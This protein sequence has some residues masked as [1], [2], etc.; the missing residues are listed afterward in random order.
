MALGYLFGQARETLRHLAPEDQFAL[1][2]LCDRIQAAEA[3][4]RVSAAGAF[5]K[6]HTVCRGI[7][8]R[9][10]D[11]N[12]VLDYPDFVYILN[13]MPEMAEKVAVCLENEPAFFAA[14][15]IFLENGT[16]PCIFPGTIMPEVCITTFC[17]YESPAK[18]EIR[19]LK[20][21]FFQL[22]W[23]LG[24]LKFRIALRKFGRR[25]KKSNPKDKPE[26]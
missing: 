15:C 17:S 16:G 19:L 4:L 23:F 9:N 5:D 25:L 2:G 21:R 14:D 22:N 8:C 10:I 20:W 26:Y 7:C 6:C 18:E 3:E 13:R 11:L 1:D 12:A 24:T